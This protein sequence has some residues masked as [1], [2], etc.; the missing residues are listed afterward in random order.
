MR[1]RTAFL[2]VLVSLF[3]VLAGCTA[4]RSAF[5]PGESGTSPYDDTTAVVGPLL[6]MFGPV[7]ILATTVLSVVGTV[8]ARLAQKRGVQVRKVVPALI[9]VVRAV[10]KI[11]KEN[12]A[13]W[14]QMRG[15]FD[16]AL[17]EDDDRVIAHFRDDTTTLERGLEGLERLG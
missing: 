6:S 17:G 13:L 3:L 2:V 12:P 11:R 14:E 5:T 15:Y 4:L 8:G 16:S 7:G 1:T 9:G 10:S